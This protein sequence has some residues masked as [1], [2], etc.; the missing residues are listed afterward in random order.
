MTI[1][2]IETRYAGCR[3][4]SRLEARWAV[5]FD[6][7]QLEWEYE[8]QGYTI[9]SLVGSS[10]PYLPDFWLP[11]LGCW[12]EVKGELAADDLRMLVLAASRTGLPPALNGPVDCPM[13]FG[14]PWADRIL[15]LGNIP[16]P[17]GWAH[18]RLD[19]MA[20]DLVVAQRVFFGIRVS[21]VVKPIRIGDPIPLNQYLAGVEPEAGQLRDLNHGYAMPFELQQTIQDA[22][23]AGRSARFEHGESG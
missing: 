16:E 3:F 1:A 2:A 17:G 20:E 8:P 19:L 9:P 22:Y 23:R 5:V 12:C 15:I 11:G 18:V 14:W 4:R 21:E 6:H 10:V 13:G 7:L